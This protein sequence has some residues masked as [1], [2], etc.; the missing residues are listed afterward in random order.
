MQGALLIVQRTTTGPVPPVWVKVAFGVAALE[1]VPV[2]PLTTLQVPVP[3]TGVLPPNPVVVPF[4]QTVCAPP[5]VAVDGV[6]LMVIVTLAVEAV[7]GALLIVHRKTTGPAPPVCVNV[8]LGRPA[9][10]NVP[11]PPLTMLHVP[12][13]VVGVLPPSPVVVPPLQIVCGPPTVAAVGA[14]LTVIVTFA[15]DAVHGALLMVHRTTTGPVPPVCVNVAFGAAALE[16]VPVPPL[17]TLHAPVPVVGLLPPS[18]VVVPP[19][20][21]VCAPPTVAALG[22]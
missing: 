8:E 21:I 10:A 3:V 5:T 13:P 9:L 6:W 19:P 7:H 20:Q 14:G 4:A 22:G 18:P 16:N 17:T 12:V 15:V 11:V 2:P 1:K